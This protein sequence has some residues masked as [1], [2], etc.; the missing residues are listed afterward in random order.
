MAE[1][2]RFALVSCY[3]KTDLA[4][5]A[6]KLF[7]QG[8]SI[9]STGGTY[10][11][12][13]GTYP[14]AVENGLLIRVEDVTGFPEILGGRVKTLHPMIHGALLTDW[15]NVDHLYEADKH[16]I[17]Y[18]EVVVCNL[19]PFWEVNET[20]TPEEAVEMIDIGG[21]AM[22]RA[23]AKNHKHIRVYTSPK[24][25]FC[26]SLTNSECAAEVFKITM[27]YDR[28]IANH[29]GNPE[30]ESIRSYKLVHPLK[31][32]CNPHQASAG[33]YSIN[34]APVPFQVLNGSPSYINILDAAGCWGLVRELSEVTHRV[35]AC[36]FKHTSPAGAAVYMPWQELDESIRTL[37]EKVYGMQW[38]ST[39]KPLNAYMRARNGDPMSS[40]GDFIGISAEV[41]KELALF[42]KQ[43]IS[44]GIVAP[45][46]TAE[47][48]EV[49]K[50]KKGGNYVI[51]EADPSVAFKGVE[52]RELGG[53]ALAQPLN[54]RRITES[55]LG[56][57]SVDLL[58]ANAC[59][60]YAQSNNVA[61][62]YQGQLVGLSAGQQS[63]VH[64]VR[65]AC[66]KADVWKRRHHSAAI[67][68]LE[69]F[70]DDVKP[71]DR[72]NAT[73]AMAEDCSRFLEEYGSLLREDSDFTVRQLLI[74]FIAQN[75]NSFQP[76]LSMA[77]D[78]FFPF[79]DSIH[80]AARNNI[81]F[82]SQPGGSTRD[83]EVTEACREH[84]IW[85]VHT[86]VRI[87]TH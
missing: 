39:N 9:I 86:G 63:R 21:V 47:A 58:V 29:L 27:R 64:S 30:A 75:K 80:A 1:R 42:I 56:I 24:Q 53:M 7:E 71:Q 73:T 18:I 45:G 34:G 13:S 2:K 33:I 82:I 61:C 49:L 60:K 3:D 48:L 23:A 52:F 79:P 68:M 83:D 37:L 35:A 22:M 84:G 16:R 40:F 69:Q 19:Y 76:E 15:D 55:D 38:D 72:I 6:G 10:K 31:Y 70:R 46:Y 85:M 44:D 12:L 5:F 66:Q 51:I 54:T 87:F 78:A 28:M 4:S 43:Q 36:S 8:Y 81:K 20:T 65:L 62:A 32:G 67:A 11:H 26:D 57:E 14:R 74:P 59:L 77:S 50:T 25:Y 17:P 41:D